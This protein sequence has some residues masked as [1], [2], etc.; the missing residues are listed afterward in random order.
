MASLLDCL[1]EL[2]L[3]GCAGAE[4]S[5]GDNFA[6]LGNKVSQGFYILVVDL[7]FFVGAKSANFFT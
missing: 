3:M 2:A 1:T 6:A 5:S 7:D 4:D